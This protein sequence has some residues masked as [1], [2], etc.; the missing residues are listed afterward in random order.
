MERS[1]QFNTPFQTANIP[2]MPDSEQTAQPPNIPNMPSE[3]ANVPNMPAENANVPNMPMEHTVIPNMTVDSTPAPIISDSAPSNPV[4]HTQA[5]IFPPALLTPHTLLKV[6]ANAKHDRVFRIDPDLN[7]IEWNS[8]KKWKVPVVNIEWIKE[9]RTD[10]EAFIFNALLKP[11][12]VT[13]Y[14]SRW[15]SIVYVEKGEY[16]SLNLVAASSELRNVWVNALRE[17]G[18]YGEKLPALDYLQVR[19]ES[20]LKKIWAQADRNN[21]KT[22]DYSEVKNLFEQLNIF[23]PSKL[24]KLKFKEVNTDGSGKLDFQAFKNLVYFCRQRQDLRQL[25]K[26]LVSDG[27]E[28]FTRQEFLN[29]LL[30]IQKHDLTEAN[31]V[32][33][34]YCDEATGLV[35]FSGLENYLLSDDGHYFKKDRLGVYQDMDL[36][37]SYYYIASSHNTY[38]LSDQLKGESS[39][40]GYIRALRMGCRCVELDCWDGADG[41]PIIYHGYT[42][43]SKILFRD[44]ILAIKKYGFVASPYPLILSLEMHCSLTQ[45]ERIAAILVEILGDSLLTS[46][47]DVAGISLPSPTKLKNKIM[48]KGKIVRSELSEEVVSSSDSEAASESKPKTKKVKVAKALSDL[49]V[50]CKAVHFQGF[51][52]VERRFDEISSFKEHT[53]LK[54][55][56][57]DFGK[58]IKYNQLQLSRIY[59]SGTRVNSSNYDPTPH[60]AAGCQVVAL[61]Y[62]TYDRSMDLNQA[63]FKGNGGCGYILKPAYLLKDGVTP[64]SS[65]VLAVEIISAQQ[66]PKPQESE[67]GEVVDPY[68]EIEVITPG[69]PTQKSKTKKVEDNGFNPQWNEKFVFNVPKFGLSFLRVSI[70]DKDY[71]RDQ[72]LASHSSLL[73]NI[74]PG[75]RHLEL[76]NFAGELIPFGSVFVRLDFPDSENVPVKASTF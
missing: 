19:F 2:N 6:S 29:F 36:P 31:E 26:V 39:V 44:V 67:D 51:D 47:I 56:E 74:K 57:E 62:Q 17:V 69:T 42:L 8:G 46:S 7:R 71:H 61:N 27:S 14:K 3:G 4:S 49:V 20:W 28:S 58:Y 65:A 1:L 63:L 23:I 55:C 33:L 32:Y 9:V 5:K 68:C 30:D 60:W 16:K 73:G 70:Y 76:R 11:N 66:L 40:E 43:T 18:E 15:F 13:L 54:F 12:E 41:E 52:G 59:P 48:I 50:Y 34:K 53:S 75:Y 64:N 45:Q 21:D 72:F 35:E 22:L 10:E 38:L 37:L 24:L 25:F